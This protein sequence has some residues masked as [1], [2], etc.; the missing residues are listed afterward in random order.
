MWDLMT[1]AHVVGRRFTELMAEVG[2]TPTQ[3]AVLRH[4]AEHEGV[5]QAELARAVLVSPQSVGVLLAPM[6]EQGLV[7]RDGPGGRG[8]RAGISL[9]A[10][11]RWALDRAW[12]PVLDFNSPAALGL[13]PAQAAMLGE[14]LDRIRTTLRVPSTTGTAEAPAGS[15]GAPGGTAAS[16][17]PG[18]APPGW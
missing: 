11:G 7:V 14:I 10:A 12:G 8:R 6:L 15:A 5:T 9:T 13:S 2:L 18:G 1:T 4:L 16:P 3:F 17:A